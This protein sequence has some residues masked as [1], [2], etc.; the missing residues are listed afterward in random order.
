MWLINTTSLQLEKF[1][2]CPAKTYAILSHTWGADAEELDFDEFKAGQGR[3]KV[4][5]EKIRLC[6]EEAQKND[7]R[8]A[9]VDTCCI[10]KRSSTELSEAINSMFA[11]YAKSKVCYVYLADVS[12]KRPRKVFR[13]KGF[14]KIFE[15]SRWFT[16]GWTLQELIA[17]DVL[18][19]FTREWSEL[20]DKP[21]LAKH[22]H[23]ITGI[24]IDVL[25]L[26]KSFLDCTVAQRM[27]WASSRHTSRLED[28]AYC[29]IGLFDVNLPLMYGEGSKAFLRLQRQ[30]IGQ[31][32][33]ETIF[34]WTDAPI[35]G[36]GLL[37]P[38]V[39]HFADAATVQR[40]APGQ[41][42]GERPHYFST[43]KGLSF[44]SPLI[45]Y[46]LN[47]YLVPLHCCRDEKQ[48]AIF[49]TKT[50][51]GDK[52]RRTQYRGRSFLDAP[53][54]NV[55]KLRMRTIFIPDDS[56]GLQLAPYGRLPLLQIR[57]DLDIWHLAP[58]KEQLISLDDSDSDDGNEDDEEGHGIENGASLIWPRPTTRIRFRRR[59]LSKG[60]A[61]GCGRSKP[62][63]GLDFEYYLHFSFDEDFK[64]VCA[65]YFG[66]NV[67]LGT[68]VRWD[69]F[70]HEF[71]FEHEYF[72]S[73]GKS[74]LSR[75]RGSARDNHFRHGIRRPIFLRV[76]LYL[77]TY[78]EVTLQPLDGSGFELSINGKKHRHESTAGWYFGPCITCL[79][80]TFIGS[81]RER[82]LGGRSRSSEYYFYL[83]M[84]VFIISMVSS[85]MLESSSVSTGL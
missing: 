20:G 8:Y 39:K 10:D 85:H 18:I 76:P 51:K 71:A 52:Y 4:G 9:W 37:A 70:E 65:L 12:W 43:N 36:S 83:L 66:T 78:F 38:S 21:R 58:K 80:E 77:C 25:E 19:F 47:T 84:S 45:P 57:S 26:R 31:T 28:I 22:V 11:W 63:D 5:F 2:E 15:K 46:S 72:L 24:D 40:D 35:E 50:F 30:I 17:P 27:S 34:A 61:I 55:S 81:T 75:F 74:L 79:E 1:Q 6:C 16:R 48:L 59:D 32:D 49:L 7:I 41:N 53:D 60:V 33:D 69:S 42:Y 56:R 44:Q 3:E 23:S 62:E 13:S 64:P 68:N 29:L 67:R 73:N 82:S 14:V 54:W